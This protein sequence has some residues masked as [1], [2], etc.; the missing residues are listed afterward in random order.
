[1]LCAP[2]ASPIVQ[3]VKTTPD[4]P[5]P[6]YHRKSLLW[7]QFGRMRASILS[8][9]S[10]PLALMI[11]I[12]G[13][14]RL[15]PHAC[16]VCLVRFLFIHTLASLDR[17]LTVSIFQPYQADWRN[18]AILRYP[19]LLCVHAMAQREGATSSAILSQCRGMVTQAQ[20]RA[21]DHLAPTFRQSP[22]RAR[23]FSRPSPEALLHSRAL[24]PR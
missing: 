13:F 12:L 15:S 24:R 19:L 14:L 9:H 22:M 16:V 6:P 1:M 8:L 18:I 20:T 17:V 23:S 3:P 7:E 11:G 10:Q 2:P 4:P 21:A 5:S